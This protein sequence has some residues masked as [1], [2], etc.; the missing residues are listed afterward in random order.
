[1]I[2][3]LWAY[4][5]NNGRSSHG[6]LGP[7]LLGRWAMLDKTT[8]ELVAGLLAAMSGF[9]HRCRELRCSTWASSISC[10]PGRRA[11]WL[12]CALAVWILGTG[13]WGESC[14]AASKQYTQEYT[15]IQ[16][17]RAILPAFK[18]VH[19]VLRV[20]QG[21]LR[22]PGGTLQLAEFPLRQVDGSHPC[23]ASTHG[24][25]LCGQS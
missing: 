10:S 1:M 12:P 7:L 22:M 5:R 18:Q 23:H 11:K 21:M 13:T 9:G 17:S 2:L 3:V 25:N 8:G 4:S 16:G 15:R 20:Q 19:Q 6:N 24:W 14:C